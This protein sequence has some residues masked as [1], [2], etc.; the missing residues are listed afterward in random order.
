HDAATAQGGTMRTQPRR[1]ASLERVQIEH[2]DASFAW[3]G[4]AAAHVRPQ[5]DGHQSTTYWCGTP[6]GSVA[7]ASAGAFGWGLLG[8]FWFLTTW[9][10]VEKTR[11]ADCLTPAAFRIFSANSAQL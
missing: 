8:S 11:P 4:H 1:L 7:G 10:G 2:V 6:P 9:R 3:G 5:H